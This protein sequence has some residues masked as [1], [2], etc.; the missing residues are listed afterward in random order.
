M[1]VNN[2]AC[3]RIGSIEAEVCLTAQ[4]ADGERQMAVYTFERCC[5]GRAQ[6]IAREK[7][8]VALGFCEQKGRKAARPKGLVRAGRQI[9]WSQRL[10]LALQPAHLRL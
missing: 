6:R 10:H 7:P 3:A 2:L 5:I 8:D 1:L 4:Q 9:V